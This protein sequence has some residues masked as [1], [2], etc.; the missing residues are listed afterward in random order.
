MSAS[1]AIGKHYFE[2]LVPQKREVMR[3]AVEYVINT[4][5]TYQANFIKFTRLDNQDIFVNTYICPWL[6]GDGEMMGA[7]GIVTDETETKLYQEKLVRAEKMAILGQIAV[8]V[9]HEVRSPLASIRGFARIIDKNENSGSKYKEYAET[10]IQQVDR[11]NT[12]VQELLDFSKPEDNT[13]QR[14]DINQTLRKAIELSGVD[15]G[16]INIIEYLEDN[17]P[18]IV[19]DYQKI[20]CVFV[21][22]LNNAYQAISEKGIIEITT[23]SLDNSVI[24]KI[25]DNGCGIPSNLI[26]IIFDPYFTTKDMGTGLGLA[27]VQQVANN[28][29]AK[30]RVS[31]DVGLGTSFELEFPLGKDKAY[32]E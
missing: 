2:T 11:I 7:I 28:H 22:L 17:L 19:G 15:K 24:V 3:R 8:Q 25:T 23:L 9:S 31:S 30:I 10:I 16:D 29:G 32:E 5:K 13:Y 1:W 4:G 27:I 21:N 6:N 20:E 26:D 18:S 14:I 12:V